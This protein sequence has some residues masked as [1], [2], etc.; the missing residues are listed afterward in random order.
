MLVRQDIETQ[1]GELFTHYP[2]ASGQ[3]ACRYVVK[4]GS[5]A[6]PG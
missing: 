4:F 5:L 1:C 2:N 6:H 3:A